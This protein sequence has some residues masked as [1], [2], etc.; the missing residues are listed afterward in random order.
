M[1]LIDKASLLMVPSTYEAG[2]L[3]NV[4][5]SG[6]RAP[7]ETGSNSGYDQT[8]ADFTFDRGTNAAATRVN[9]DGLIEKYRENKLLQSNQFNTT[10]VTSS[11]SVTSGQS[12]YDD[13][14]NAWLFNSSGG[15]I[16]QSGLGSVSGVHTLSVYVKAGTAQGFRIRVDQATDANYII[17]LSDSSL[18]SES[19][20][21]TYKS[22]SVGTGWY[23]IEMAFV[24]NTI[25]NIQ[26]RVTDLAGATASGTA[27]IMNAQ[28]ESGLVSTDYLDSGATTA[29]AGVL[30]DLPR[31]NYDANGENGALLLE[32]SRQQ[33]FQYSEYFGDWLSNRLDA[34]AND[35]TSP[36][37]LQN[38]YKVAQQSGFTTAPNVNKGGISAGTYSISIFAKKGTWSY[39]AISFQGV[40]YFDL[41]SGTKGTINSN[42]TATIE[43][44]GSG[45]YKCTIVRTTTTTQTPAF[46]FAENDNTLTTSDTQ[47]YMYIYGAQLE[48]GSYATSYIP[49]H[50][51]SGGVTRA[52]DSCSVT[53]V[54]DILNDSEG[55]FFVEIQAQSDDSASKVLTIGDGTSANRVQIF[56]QA[57]TK[58]TTN[59][60]SGSVSQVSGFTTTYDQTQNAKVVIRYANNNAKFY[61]N[62][63]EIAS[64]TS[65][66]TPTGLDRIVF[67]NGTGASLFSGFMKQLIYFDT[68]LT[69]AEC[70]SLTS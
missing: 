68:A 24:A 64:D 16:Y 5:P 25:T 29:K 20:N 48:A 40:S 1:A 44:Y 26:F 28:L 7:D 4:L 70:I 41:D 23:R 34:T 33:L 63:S 62:G 47:G 17:D 37:G 13:S 45:W 12:G 69:D 31:I 9:T 59:V 38:A 19:G 49:N 8:R 50:G 15:Y 11:S 3:Y 18:I 58:I 60:I 53:G 35:A 54:S 42:H 67:N 61:L 2:T 30:V 55:T 52:A 6:N 57:G 36:E 10:W 46:Y 39:L 14:S 65:V 27:Y 21:I 56:Y 51:A 43:D 66:T 22:T 32:P